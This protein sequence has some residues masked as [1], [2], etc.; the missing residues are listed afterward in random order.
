MQDG[1]E[2]HFILNNSLTGMQTNE[3]VLCCVVYLVTAIIVSL[4]QYWNEN[5]GINHCSPSVDLFNSI[6][7]IYCFITCLVTYSLCYG[8][9]N[10]ERDCGVA[11]R[12]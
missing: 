8:T 6:D 7:H 11:M 1:V 3:Y 2:V 12:S 5:F 9:R 4:F 10:S